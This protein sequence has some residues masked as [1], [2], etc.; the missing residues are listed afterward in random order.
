MIAIDLSFFENL[1]AFPNQTVI[2]YFVMSYILH[3]DRLYFHLLQLME[4][5]F[6]LLFPSFYFELYYIRYH[7]CNFRNIVKPIANS[8]SDNC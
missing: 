3:S 6:L 5:T 8:P 1:Y 2:E 7:L 4:L